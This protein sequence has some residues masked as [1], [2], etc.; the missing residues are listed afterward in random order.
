M[1]RSRTI[2]RRVSAFVYHALCLALAFAML[3][4]IIWLFASSLKP[5][6]DIFTRSTELWPRSFNWQNYAQGWKGFGGI[7][8]SRFFGNTFFV[9]L[10]ST[11][12]AV[13]SSALIAF[14]LARIDFRFKAFWFG[15]VILT[16]LLPGQIITIP[17]Y[18]IF[19]GLGWVNT[20]LPLILPSFFGTPFF[21]FL[22]MQFIR[23]IP[24]ELDE[25]AE[26]DG[27]S[28]F[29]T[30]RSVILP[31]LS[32]ALVTSAIFSFYWGWD[33][34]FQP[35]IYL[36]DPARYTISVA[37]RLFSDPSSQTDWGAMFAMS[38]LS[39]VPPVLFFFVFQKNL[40]EGISTTGLK[41]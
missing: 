18:I 34:F 26:I 10:L 39:L 32:P 9:V 14:G 40:V 6:S 19:H 17:Q 37:L 15:T 22:I 20:Y 31:L 35:L 38:T 41:A 21:I 2:K 24:Q 3:Y 5:S 13:A 33:N 8:F 1:S 11:A 28:R 27:C 23:G 29:A 30:F 16:M 7:S 12:G 25:S 36:N 4:P